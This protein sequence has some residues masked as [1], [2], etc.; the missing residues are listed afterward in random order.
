MLFG[1]S[2]L[3]EFAPDPDMARRR[4]GFYKRNGA[5]EAGYDMTLFGV[6]YRVLYWAA[7]EVDPLQIARQHAAVYQ[8]RFARPLYDKY[9]TIPWSPRDGMPDRVDWAKAEEEFE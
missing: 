1:E 8:N 3:P 2:E 4:I 6:P 5:K 9:I 7:Q